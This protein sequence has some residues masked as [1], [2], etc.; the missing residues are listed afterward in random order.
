MAVADTDHSEVVGRDD[1]R[2]RATG[3]VARLVDGVGGALVVRGEPGT[4]VSTVLAEVAD[5]ASA[6]EVALWRARGRVAEHDVSCAAL[7]ELAAHDTG[8]RLAAALAPGGAGPDPGRAD[9]RTGAGLGPRLVEVLAG[10]APLLVVVDD[11]HLADP[12]SLDA[13]GFAAHRLRHLGVGV[14][15]GARRVRCRVDDLG[16]P[17]VELEG[18]SVRELGELLTARAPVAPGVVAEIH[19][20]TGGNPLAAVE[21][22][23]R[24]AP[25]ERDGTAPLPSLP[26]PGASIGE[27]FGAPLRALDAATRRA[28]CVAA[29]EP[30]GEVRVVGLA[31]VTLGDRI[32]ALEAAEEAGVIEVTDGRVR[33][34]HPLRRAAAYHLLAAPSRRAAH[35]ALAAACDAPG[36]AERRAAHLD[37]GALGPDE[38]IAADLERVARAAESRGDTATAARWWARAAELSPDGVDASRR[39]VESERARAGG[40]RPLDALTAAEL[41]VARTVGSGLSNKEAAASL[42]VSV[43]TVDA[44]LQSIYRKLRIRSR[45]ELAVLMAQA[46]GPVAAEGTR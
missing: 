16:L 31:L 5:A 22:A 19:R 1:V 11:A 28:L 17:T 15:V 27:V 21:L 25:A 43:K 44:H 10:A 12:D 36:D 40:S 14:L 3:L 35:R 6:A 34:D 9:A 2:R 39:R 7:H 23:G 4:G 8:G 37:A 38:T 24:L 45:T 32:D 13:L 30:T 29:A 46:D 18:L 33:F 26:E 20:L 41:R 42:Y